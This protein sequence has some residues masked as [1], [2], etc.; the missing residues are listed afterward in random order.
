MVNAHMKYFSEE[1]NVKDGTG[2]GRKAIMEGVMNEMTSEKAAFLQTENPMNSIGSFH[3]SITL[4]SFEDQKGRSIMFYEA[5]TLFAGLFLNA[6][7]F[8][9]E[10]GSSKDFQNTALERAFEISCAV[11]MWSCILLCIYG[12]GFWLLSIQY[13][14]TVPNWFLGH[15]NI[16]I[17]L[18][19]LINLIATSTLTSIL[20]AFWNRLQDHPTDAIVLI[21]LAALL[22]VKSLFTNHK[23]FGKQVPLELYHGPKWLRIL[24]GLAVTKKVLKENAEKRAA[25]LTK[26]FTNEMSTVGSSTK[27]IVGMSEVKTLLE[28]ACSRLGKPNTDLTQY[29]K[30]LEDNWF[31]DIE[32]LEGEDVNVLSNYMPRV[33]AKSVHEILQR[34]EKFGG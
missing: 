5:T 15:Q 20:I 31:D 1:T 13:S 17:E 14:N 33:L 24:L 11:N 27:D 26:H 10:Y 6:V 16:I 34:K 8:V 12:G 25:F 7:W 23:T 29:L 2:A 28:K 30:K 3:T 19:L 9:W 4:T 32:R 22:F 21:V 18:D